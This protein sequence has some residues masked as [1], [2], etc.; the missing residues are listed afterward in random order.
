M[1]K[2]NL[3]VD[4]IFSLFYSTT[5]QSRFISDLKEH[6]VLLSTEKIYFIITKKSENIILKNNTVIW[7]KLYVVWKILIISDIAYCTF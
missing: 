4:F 3:S 6:T 2:S 1:L 7:N 5:A